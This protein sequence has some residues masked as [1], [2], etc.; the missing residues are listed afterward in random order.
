M[1]L[2]GSPLRLNATAQ[3]LRAARNIPLAH[4][5]TATWRGNATVDLIRLS[6]FGI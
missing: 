3:R 1:K 2:S 6:V 5:N 4:R